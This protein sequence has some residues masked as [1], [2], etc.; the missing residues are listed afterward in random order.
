M[1]RHEYELPCGASLADLLR[2]VHT[3]IA[4]PDP[5]T[6]RRY[7]EGWN[8][9]GIIVPPETYT[10]QLRS[11]GTHTYIGKG[12]WSGHIAVV[13]RMHPQAWERYTATI[14]QPIDSLDAPLAESIVGADGAAY[15][16]LSFN[17]NSYYEQAAEGVLAVILDQL[18]A[19]YTGRFTY[20]WGYVQHLSHLAALPAE[21]NHLIPRGS[22]H[23]D[24]WKNTLVVDQQS[25]HP[26]ASLIEPY[27]CVST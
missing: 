10:P 8:L 19:G 1:V 17:I 14:E 22:V 26:I 18:A 4:H 9:Q 20:T 21:P 23:V 13:V 3:L 6:N 7:E 11:V 15:S 25:T 27:L 16:S 2:S 12:M 5:L 24:Q